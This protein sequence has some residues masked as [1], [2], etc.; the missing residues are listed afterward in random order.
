MLRLDS[1]QRH[2]NSLSRF[3][4]FAGDHANSQYTGGGF[5]SP[6]SFDWQESDLGQAVTAKKGV[7]VF[8]VE[9]EALI[10][11]D[12]YER[13]ISLGYAVCGKAASGEM[14]M[15]TIFEARPDI[16]LMDV[17][18]SG[19]M[20]GVETAL[21][22]RERLDVPLVYLTAYSE[23]DLIARA[24]KEGGYGYLV[25]PFD[26]RELHATLQVALARSQAHTE[27]EATVAERTRALRD[28]VAELETFSYAV[29]HDLRVPLMTLADSASR[30]AADHAAE[31]DAKGLLRVQQMQAELQRLS[32]LTTSLLDFAILAK[33]PVR[34][35]S[36]AIQ[37]MVIQI[38]DETHSQA[39]DRTLEIA[40]SAMPDAICD[41][42]LVEQVWRNLLGN[43][44][45]FS[46]GRDPAVIAAGFDATVGAWYVRDNG[47]GFDMALAGELFRP[48]LRLHA[49]SKF[50]GHGIGLATV[51]RVIRRHGGR[52]WAESNPGKGSVFYFTLGGKT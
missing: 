14:A 18:L 48:F 38:V 35:E 3:P 52:I 8:V 44:V 20:D 5:V 19:R 23:P 31:L 16:I 7:R 28:T 26:E 25:K 1:I 22:I 47:V 37:T 40:V 12:I 9:D 39:G 29:A 32:A 15:R 6:P 43:A 13:L 2:E 30:L 27:L 51:E 33:E 50:Q 11:M 17:S 45:K 46:A 36:V 4:F 49:K 42:I 10:A 24:T 34:R 21:L 41:P